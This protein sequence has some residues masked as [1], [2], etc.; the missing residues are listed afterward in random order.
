MPAESFNDVMVDR[1]DDI[2][3]AKCGQSVKLDNVKPLSSMTCPGCGATI[4]VP[5]KIGQFMLTRLMGAGAMGA[6]FEATDT[7]L[8]RRVAVKVMRRQQGDDDQKAMVNF[9]SEARALA[10]VNHRNVVQVHTIGQHRGQPYIVMEL[11][12][13]PTQL[14][15]IVLRREPMD[16]KRVLEIGKDVA[17]GLAVAA[18]LKLIHGDIK[19]GN[20][21]LAADGTAKVVDFGLVRRAG[22]SDDEPVWGTPYYIAPERVRGEPP[23]M[24][25]D[26]FSLGAT[27][28]HLLVGSPPFTGSTVKEVIA[29]RMAGEAPN[30]LDARDDVNKATA[31]VIG[32][33]IALDPSKRYEDYATV[34]DRLDNALKALEARTIER[35]SRPSIQPARR[36]D[37]AKSGTVKSAKR[38]GKKKSS[39]L[40][41]IIFAA[42][43]VL[44]LGL[45][46]SM[47]WFANRQADQSGADQPQD[48]GRID[49]DFNGPALGA[50]WTAVGGG[51]FDKSGHYVL[52]VDKANPGPVGL[53]RSL[54]DGKVTCDVKLNPILGRGG[55]MSIAIDAPDGGGL[56]LTLSHNASLKPVLSG[57]VRDGA[58]VVKTAVAELPYEPEA[59]SLRIEWTQQFHEW[60]VRY[61]L[62][63]TDPFEQHPLGRVTVSES[64]DQART[65]RMELSGSGGGRMTVGLDAVRIE[66]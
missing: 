24:R 37:K 16:E 3:C 60:F 58:T 13:G 34:I 29:A 49:E 48:T 46:G 2:R 21:L 43:I 22:K 64:G 11:V 9:L 59:M 26:I 7:T 51:S 45:I 6:V 25:T 19:P 27:L 28:W 17:E 36:V 20:I 33:M 31:H 38:P 1:I 56:R 54:P 47:V 15:P 50:G 32:R 57:E 42:I 5:G 39:G 41:L 61:R 12:N 44:L 4:A 10:A 35:Q 18:R 30:L 23:S 55:N 63:P 62:G 66:P 53:S 52:A 8:G 65:L 40:Q 14:E